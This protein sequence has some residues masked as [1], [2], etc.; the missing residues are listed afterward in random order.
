MTLPKVILVDIIPPDTTPEESLARLNELEHLMWTYGGFVIIRKIQ[1]RQLPNY[2]TYIGKGKLE[3]I[4]EEAVEKKADYIVINNILK[5][6]QIYNLEKQVE[7]KGIKVWDRIDLIL[8]IFDKHATTKEAKLQIEL[9]GLRHLG[10][11]IFKMGLDLMRQGGGIGTRGKGETNIEVM[12]RHIAKRE[13]GIKQYLKKIEK[14]HE[15]QRRKRR[16][17]GFKTAAIV[18]YTNAGKSSLLTALTKKNVKIKDELFAT[19][20]SHIGKVFLPEKQECALLSDTIGFIRDL[21]PELIDA[22]H[23]TLAET[24][25]ADLI[26]NVI[27]ADDLEL[28][29]KIKVVEEVLKK[30]KC[31]QKPILHIFNKIDRIAEHRRK[32]LASEYK[33]LHPLFV[34]AREKMNLEELKQKIGEGLT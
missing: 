13:Q 30:L 28:D 18:G 3:E 17:Y 9:A 25:D 8:K 24:I 11:R 14:N 34:S 4:L 2:Q 22:F 23:S 26:L 29:W 32:A 6:Q 1:K 21:P 10:P 12:K 5:P 16:D 27:D 19:L 31:D 33:N 20:D 7:Q 15:G